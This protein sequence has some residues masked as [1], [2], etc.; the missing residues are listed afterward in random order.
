MLSV[1]LGIFCVLLT[2]A[3]VIYELQNRK[4]RERVQ[5]IG[6]KSEKV[7]RSS[8]D[9]VKEAQ[10]KFPYAVTIESFRQDDPDYLRVLADIF[11]RPEVQFF[12]EDLRYSVTRAL[13]AANDER[14]E[15]NAVGKLKGIE[16]VDREMK[17]IVAQAGETE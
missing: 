8:L 17:K 16:L 7:F 1:T 10:S 5:E 12:I 11:A 9:A 4:L 6:Q 3:A 15:Q 13:V 14:L 2:V